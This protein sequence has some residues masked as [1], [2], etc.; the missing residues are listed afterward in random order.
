[1]KQCRKAFE[2]IYRAN[3]VDGTAV[4]VATVKVGIIVA[5]LQLKTSLE[6]FG[7]DVER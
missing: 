7:W 5:P 2:T 1:M 4:I 6:N 3:C